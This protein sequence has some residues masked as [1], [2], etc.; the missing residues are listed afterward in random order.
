MRVST[1]KIV[2]LHAIF[3]CAYKKCAMDDAKDCKTKNRL[4]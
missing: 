4:K 2:T 1:E 3:S